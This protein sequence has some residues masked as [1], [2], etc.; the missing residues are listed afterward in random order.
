MNRLLSFF[1]L[2]RRVYGIITMNWETWHGFW[3]DYLDNDKDRVYDLWYN[4]YD[5][6]NHGVL[7]AIGF[8]YDLAGIQEGV[9]LSARKGWVIALD[10]CVPTG[11]ARVTGWDDTAIRIQL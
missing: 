11:Y 5:K 4:V 2:D 7:G 6:N 8:L 9:A 10:C 1:H 3:R